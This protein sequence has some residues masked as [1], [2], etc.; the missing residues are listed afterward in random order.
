MA[1]IGIAVGLTSR[2]DSTVAQVLGI[3]PLTSSAVM[4]MRLAVTTVAWWEVLLALT[5]L[6]A[7][8]WLFRRLA[9]K[10]FGAGM[11]MYGKEPTLRETLR[12][13]RQS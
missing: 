13:M 9:G 2:L 4:P 6:V 1:P 7:T 10:V 8:T 12:W 5:L 3:F 11:L